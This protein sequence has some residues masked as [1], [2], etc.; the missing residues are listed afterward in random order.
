[1]SENEKRRYDGMIRW[2]LH[3]SQ[4]EEDFVGFLTECGWT[5]EEAAEEWKYWN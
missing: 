2:F 3:R 5:E 1:M 4:F